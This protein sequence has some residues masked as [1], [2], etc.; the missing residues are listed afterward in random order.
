MNQV[1]KY[2]LIITTGL[3]LEK[4]SDAPRQIKI[5]PLDSTVRSFDQ[6][7]ADTYIEIHLKQDSLRPI[8]ILAWT[9]LKFSR[10]FFVFN[11]LK[12]LAYT[13]VYERGFLWKPKQKQF[14]VV[15]E[16]YN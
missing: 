4:T 2:S 8:D 13:I 6:S 11:L 14:S 16:P 12:I 7:V 10:Q 5:Y 3:L 9:K 15:L 1:G